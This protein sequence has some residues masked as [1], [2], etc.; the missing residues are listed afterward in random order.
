M[1]AIAKTDDLRV[2]LLDETLGL[3]ALFGLASPETNV[4]PQG[5]GIFPL[6]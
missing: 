1:F 6:L 5:C 2:E 4:L 3:R